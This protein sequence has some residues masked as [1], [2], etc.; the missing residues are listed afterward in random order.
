MFCHSFISIPRLRDLKPNPHTQFTSRPVISL[1]NCFRTLTDNLNLWITGS[2]RMLVFSG[3]AQSFMLLGEVLDYSDVNLNMREDS[4]V[5]TNYTI[6][7]LWAHVSAI[8][9]ILPILFTI[10][11]GQNSD[12]AQRS[13]LCGK[14][15]LHHIFKEAYE[16]NVLCFPRSS[17]LI[18]VW[19]KRLLGRES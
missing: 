5:T 11:G 8:W 14:V 16:Y 1:S 4:Q 6:L 9:D 13:K 15:V 7:S 10:T 19:T 2:M 3:G 12:L 18:A 17:V